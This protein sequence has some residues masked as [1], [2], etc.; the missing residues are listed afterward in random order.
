MSLRVILRHCLS[1]LIATTL[2]G[3]AVLANAQEPARYDRSKLDAW[4]VRYAG[5][6]PDFKPGDVLTAKDS[7]KLKPFVPPGMLEKM[8][9]PGFQAAIAEHRDYRPRAD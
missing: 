4:L 3:A 8:M 7:E 5:A 2:L 6:K 9:F 1:I